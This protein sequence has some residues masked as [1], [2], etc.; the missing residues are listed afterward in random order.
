MKI[1]TVLL[2][3]LPLLP[4]F[5]NADD[6]VVPPPLSCASLS[7]RQLWQYWKHPTTAS[8][9]CPLGQQAH[10]RQT[11]NKVDGYYDIVCRCGE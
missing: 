2:L 3:L 7:S 8:I 10:C 4:A 5:M 6:S 9:C 1:L 11:N